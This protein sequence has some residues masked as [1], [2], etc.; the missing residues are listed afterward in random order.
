MSPIML[1]QSK[2]RR[3]LRHGFTLVELLVV[4]AIIGV[5]VS[6][7][8]P[9]VQMVR[10]AARKTQCQN[11]L[12]QLSLALHNYQ[13]A[14]RVIP[15]AMYEKDDAPFAWT[16]GT[17]TL[18]FVEQSNLYQSFDLGQ[19]PISDKN[20]ELLSVPL[21]VF[22]CP[23][24]KAPRHASFLD[25]VSFTELEVTIDNY[26]YNWEI[27]SFENGRHCRFQDVLD[28]LSNTA[29]QA[30]TVYSSRSVDEVGTLVGSPSASCAGLGLQGFADTYVALPIVI[31]WGGA[32]PID[33]PIN[34]TLASH[35]QGGAYLSLFDGS[36]R[37]LSASASP[38]VTGAL[39]TLN[40]GEVGTDF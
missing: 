22:R 10:E 6:L 18:P 19:S 28:G 33:A 34:N 26:G 38:E 15:L 40:G 21:T 37:F 36:V 24:E 2:A 9:A 12:K 14:H 32:L 39:S 27:D 11:N 35:H 16:W 7:L 1:Q 20:V 30:E 3:S 13:S 17:M 4:L 8:L 29:L 5:L 31:V 25:P 23:S